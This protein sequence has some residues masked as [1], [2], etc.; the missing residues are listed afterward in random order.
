MSEVLSWTHP[1]VVADLPPEGA[2]FALKPDEGVRAELARHAGVQAVSALAARFRVTP[3]GRGGAS[4][5]GDLTATVRQACVVTLELFDNR[6]EERI[7]ARFA[8]EAALV[9][10]T[11]LDEDPP[12]PIV[13]GMLDL[14]ALV[15]EFLALS[16]DPYPRKP[17][18]VFTPP[19][20]PNNE[21]DSPFAVLGKLKNTGV[22]G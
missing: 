2:E 12:D 1:V 6:I 14:G 15:A 11:A 13:D 3:D 21:T 18:A 16:I 19:S 8:P 17:G 5:E 4:V 9:P 22:K 10:G 7:A 20:E